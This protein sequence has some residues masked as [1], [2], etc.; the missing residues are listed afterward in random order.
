[1]S[2]TK[3]QK[4]QINKLIDYRDQI[5][6]SLFHIERIL[7]EYFPEEFDVAYQH[8]IPQ[9][10]T[11]LYEDKKWLSRSN[12]NMQNTIDRLLDKAKGSDDKGVSRYI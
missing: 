1:M 3:E 9:I 7:K 4:H 2:L 6:N 5:E 8:Y 12:Q 10:T 11:A